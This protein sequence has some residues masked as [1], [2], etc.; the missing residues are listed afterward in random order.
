MS[1]LFFSEIK[2]IIWESMFVRVIIF[3]ISLYQK[4]SKHTS[5]KCRYYPTCSCYAI[6]A[7]KKFGLIKGVWVSAK[8]IL[9]CNAFFSGGIDEV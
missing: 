3:F 1:W 4:I 9:K 8:R 6:K 7:L 5:K 2:A